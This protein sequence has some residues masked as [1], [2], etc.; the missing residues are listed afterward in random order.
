V[1]GAVSRNDSDL[2][3]QY[4]HSVGGGYTMWVGRTTSG[5]DSQAVSEDRHGGDSP[6]TRAPV[7]RQSI[8]CPGRGSTYGAAGRGWPRARRSLTRGAG[9]LERGGNS[10]EGVPSPRARRSLTRGA[11][12]LERGGNSPEGASSPRAR[13]VFRVAAPAPQARRRFAR[14]APGPAVCWAAEVSWSTGLS[15]PW[16]VAMRGVICD[17]QI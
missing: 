17:L 10:P 16:A 2:P 6:L 5:S 11:G 4:L 1:G 14:G 3:A 9:S 7:T 8:Q 13:Q 12:S 15:L